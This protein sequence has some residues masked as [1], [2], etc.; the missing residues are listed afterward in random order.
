MLGWSRAAAARASRSKRVFSSSPQPAE[1]VGLIDL[2]HPPDAEP[3]GDA[4][5][6]DRTADHE[7]EELLVGR[8][9]RES[10]YVTLDVRDQCNV[11]EP[12]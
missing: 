3:G 8:A 5:M 4:V 12:G 9:S 7:L 11:G 1:V 6:R 10:G 2:S